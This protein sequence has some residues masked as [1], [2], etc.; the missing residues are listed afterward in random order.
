MDIVDDVTRGKALL[1]DVRTKD[2]WGTGHAKGAIRI[3][4]NDILSGHTGN[5]DP[6]IPIY[7]YCA[8]GGRA[9]SAAA[10]LNRQGY[11]ATNIGGLSQWTALGGEIVK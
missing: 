9:G 8:S 6:D 11:D 10:Y 2:E 1:L 7:I 3:S 5:L 4:V